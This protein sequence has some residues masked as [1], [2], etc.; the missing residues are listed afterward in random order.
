MPDQAYSDP[1]DEARR[2]A[3]SSP[4]GLPLPM[5]RSYLHC[6]HC[7]WPLLQLGDP[8]THYVG[9]EYDPAS[10]V[11]NRGTW[12]EIPAECEECGLVTALVVAFHKGEIRVEPLRRS[13]RLV[14]RV[15]ADK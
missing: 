7:G 1:T 6:A 4:A 3:A 10:P 12:I 9:D 14:S 5:Q 8:I 11:N 13:L 15:E 2:Q